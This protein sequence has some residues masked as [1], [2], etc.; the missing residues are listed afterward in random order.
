[1]ERLRLTN[2]QCH[3][4]WLAGAK[5]ARCPCQSSGAELAMPRCGDGK[6]EVPETA[7]TCF[8]DC[9]GVT[10]PPQCGEEPHSDPQGHAVVDGRGHHV[11]SAA[12]CCDACAAGRD[13]GLGKPLSDSLGNQAVGGRS[14][15]H[16]IGKEP[17]LNARAQAGADVGGFDVDLLILGAPI[18]KHRVLGVVDG[19]ERLH[20]GES[21]AN[22]GCALAHAVQCSN[23]VGRGYA[24]RSVWN[25]RGTDETTQEPPAKKQK[26]DAFINDDDSD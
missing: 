23:P 5:D 14:R 20:N 9:P 2:V 11:A 24:D 26:V 17:L 1:M 13:P 4:N 18:T 16:T 7:A 25:R 10:T 15:V 6:C 12:A 3:H 21:S 19:V 22:V 8:A